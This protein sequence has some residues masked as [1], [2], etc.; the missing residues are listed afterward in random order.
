MF[1]ELARHSHAI[2]MPHRPLEC[3]PPA[4]DT[5]RRDRIDGGEQHELGNIDAVT[6]RLL[7]R[8]RL[9]GRE[10]HMLVLGVQ[11]METQRRDAHGYRVQ[12][13]R[14]RHQAEGNG[15]GCD[16][17]GRHGSAHRKFRATTRHKA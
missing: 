5:E 3:R 10:H 15:E 14:D 8:P 7:Q 11:Q 2:T 17:A 12:L 13:H 6:A 1:G 4:R 16:G 9:L